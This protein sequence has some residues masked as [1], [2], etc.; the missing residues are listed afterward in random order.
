MRL[1]LVAL[2][3]VLCSL[4]SVAHADIEVGPPP[5]DAQSSSGGGGGSCA[6]TPGTTEGAAVFAT[7][8][9]LGVASFVARRRARRDAQ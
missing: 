3:T 8:G 6:A 7:L 2:L 9:A 4:A 1:T 5:A